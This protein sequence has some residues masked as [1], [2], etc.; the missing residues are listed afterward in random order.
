MFSKGIIAFFH[1]H[2]DLVLILFLQADMFRYGSFKI[3]KTIKRM[4]KV[5]EACSIM[6]VRAIFASGL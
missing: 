6:V 1:V 3:I 4:R 2:Y 5:E